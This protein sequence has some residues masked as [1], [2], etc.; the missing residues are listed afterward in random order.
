MATELNKSV[1]RVTVG[2]HRG[3]KLVVSLVVGD[4]IEIREKGRRSREYISIAGVFDFAIKCRVEHERL[5]KRQAKK[6][7]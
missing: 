7:K 3:R 4:L 2:S 1:T 5:W 6:N